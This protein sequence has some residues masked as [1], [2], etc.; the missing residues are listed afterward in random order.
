[1]LEK[2]N[3]FRLRAEGE[4]LE[5][6]LKIP[7]HFVFD[8]KYDL[9]RRARLVAGGNHTEALKEDIFSGVVKLEVIKVCFLIGDLHELTVCAGDIGSAFLQGLTREKIYIIAG[10]EFGPLA[11]QTLIV[12]KAL[13]GLKTS[14]ARFHEQHLTTTLRKMGYEPSKADAD[15]M[16]KDCGSHYEYIARY[17]DDILI[18]SKHPLKIIE[19]L[20]KTYTMKGVGEPEFYLGGDVQILGPEWEK[21]HQDCTISQNICH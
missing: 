2:D 12:Y 14:A 5:E 9:R 4:G 19:E 13:Y 11:G 21:G 6:Y 7:Y 17:V 8:V 10:P 20:K 16:I 15:L 18:W 1:M 3:T